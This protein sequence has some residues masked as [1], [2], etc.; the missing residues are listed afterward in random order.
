VR[1]EE[2]VVHGGEGEERAGEGARELG[3][4][5]VAVVTS[6]FLPFLGSA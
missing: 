5:E 6:S 1:G 4:E 2:V 3:A